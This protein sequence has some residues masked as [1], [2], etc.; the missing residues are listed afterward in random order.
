MSENTN[1]KP[2]INM[3][4]FNLSWLYVIIAMSFAIL[5][6]SN[7]EGG[8][9]K[10]ITYTEFKDMINKGYANKIIAYDDNTV[11][12]YIK[13]EF[14]KDVYKYYS[15]T[16]FE[17]FLEDIDFEEELKELQME[18]VRLSK[19]RVLTMRKLNYISLEDS[20]TALRNLNF[21]ESM[22]FPRE[23]EEE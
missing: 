13:P 1:N 3:P 19:Y 14:V 9:D 10:Q 11:E 15:F 23:T 8:I 21:S 6:F 2:K 7:Q 16:L 22:I 12:M 18:S 5:Y 4:R 17:V 20:Y